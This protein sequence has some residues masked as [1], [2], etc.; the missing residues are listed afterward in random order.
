VTIRLLAMA[1][2]L[3][4]PRPRPRCHR[5]RD[6]EW[7]RSSVLLTAWLA[8]TNLSMSMHIDFL[9]IGTMKNPSRNRQLCCSTLSSGWRRAVPTHPTAALSTREHHAPPLRCHSFN[10]MG[11]HGSSRRTPI[12]TRDRSGHLPP[13]PIGLPGHPPPLRHVTSP[14]RKRQ[15]HTALR[16]RTGVHDHPPIEAV[17]STALH[18]PESMS[19]HRT[20]SSDG[21]DT[22]CMRKR[23]VMATDYDA[24]RV[25]EPDETDTS[26]EQ[27]TASRKDTQFPRRGRRRHR[28]RRILQVARRRPVR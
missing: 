26:L 10:D 18:A 21:S 1:P 17:E 4:V 3:P 25:T 27:L 13:P 14:A 12:R 28:H 11:D 22:Q 8:A 6:A 16:N 23:S 19:R 24:P 20:L 9:C 5:G 15:R 7:V 2:P